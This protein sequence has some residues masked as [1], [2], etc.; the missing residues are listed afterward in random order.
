MHTPGQRPLI[1]LVAAVVVLCAGLAGGP[2]NAQ[3]W[4]DQATAPSPIATSSGHLHLA[5]LRPVH[6]ES[7]ATAKLGSTLRAAAGPQS[8]FVEF[9]GPTV[10][11]ASGAST[12]ATAN[13]GAAQGDTEAGARRATAGTARAAQITATASEVARAARSHDPAARQ[14]FT[15]TNAVAGVGLTVDASALPALAARG[16][17]VKV[18][19]LVPKR[20]ATTGAA[21]LTEALATWQ[22][23]GRTGAGVSIGIIDTGI[24]Y[25][26]ADFGGPGTVAAY[27][28]ARA[29]DT[30]TPNAAVVG[31]YD[32]VGDTY[33]G[34]NEPQ[35]DPNPLDCE[36]HGTHVAGIAAGRGVNADGS[37][38]SGSYRTLT[39][40]RLRGLAIGPGMAPQASLYALRVFGC[41]GESSALLPALDWSLDPNGDGDVSDH[42]DIV[43][44]SL[45]SDWGSADDPDSRALDALAAH[46]VVAVA[47]AGNGGD[48]TDIGASPASAVR[49]IAVASSAD[50]YQLRDGVRV[51]APA[52]LKT[53]APGQVS[54]YFDWDGAA[55]VSGQVVTLP[56]PNADGCQPLTS[57]QRAIVRGKIVWLEWDDDERARRCGS[58][59][60]ADNV[61]AA[62]A[63]G[64]LLTS[65]T[66]RFPIGIAGSEQI[67]GLQLT[68]TAT[69]RLRAASAT[70][71]LR[72]TLSAGLRAT[73]EEFDPTLEGLIAADTARGTRTA[74]AIKP[75]VAAPGETIASAAAGT[76]AGVQ[77]ESGTSMAAPVV[78][79]IAALVKQHH[80]QWSPEQIKAAVVN[81][82]QGHLST[83]TTGRPD[84]R[85]ADHHGTGNGHRD[86]P[87]RYG[88]ARV[89]SG[90]AN[91]EA[92]VGLTS[93]A[94]NGDTEGAVSVSFGVLTPTAAH[95]AVSASHQ[96]VIENL[97][98]DARTYRL[99]Y[100]P[101]TSQPGLSYSV[102][103]TTVRVPAGQQAKVTVRVTADPFALRHSIEAS[104]AV[105]QPN[106]LL[107]D[108]QGKPELMA[109]PFLPSASGLVLVTAGTEQLRVPVYATAK[110]AS[111]TSTTLRPSRSGSDTLSV[112][113]SG[114]TATS[115]ARSGQAQDRYRSELSVLTLG[116]ESPRLPDCSAA[117][118][119]ACV[120]YPSA[121]GT[122]LRYVGA[123]ATRG[124]G[125]GRTLWFGLATWAPWTTISEPSM[126]PSVEV[127][128]TGDEVADFA[129]EVAA[130]P[131]TD[132]RY[133]MVYD[134][135]SGEVVGAEPTNFDA[136]D[137]RIFD[138]DV[139][140]IP[141]DPSAL[142]LDPTA[143]SLPISYTVTT[144][145]WAAEPFAR[146]VTDPIEFDVA[147]PPV[148]VGGPLYPDDSRTRIP[149]RVTGAAPV[150]ALVLHLDGMPGQRAEVVS[151]SA[152]PDAEP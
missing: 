117:D 76:G 56:T 49:S 86:R 46:G 3:V 143:A 77:V 134:L 26:H 58:I 1:A 32:F 54:Q 2:A 121:A 8:V 71:T 83:A 120:P 28:A 103:P 106:P 15:T 99:A 13:A 38:F 14:L 31:G 80:P 18:S 20:P 100:D 21:Q 93:L 82:A 118:V 88:P 133:A 47:S 150:S 97:G 146:D 142:G 5:G 126:L 110:P 72:V 7:P 78:S 109:R 69:S 68:G 51:D 37:T 74:G 45:T 39:D 141:V 61:A 36:G 87:E 136:T 84:D 63:I 122:D 11:E 147:V 42:L 62:G 94:Y 123:G 138:N 64:F 4:H 73:V 98:A 139:L 102:S 151:I 90:N 124:G 116:A 16:D 129:V 144:Y 65:A 145:G 135:A 52:R 115:G 29:S 57:K 12:G 127:D 59:D 149:V 30:W 119:A 131:G 89:G 128:T 132:F 91:A 105:T 130:V 55:D 43:N 101:I 10:A 41:T 6:R 95:G 148:Q 23:T 152:E 92:A 113:G 19:P 48:L 40:T 34:S 66:D 108:A 75:D 112:N 24:D 35:P 44:L 140:L 114:V 111:S 60:R 53:V 25:T 70:G 85:R 50:R 79:G 104:M 137:S 33:D 96:V 67:P 9:S 22:R 125:G 107:A 81:G 17:V 27:E